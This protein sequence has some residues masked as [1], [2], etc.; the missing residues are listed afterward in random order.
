MDLFANEVR[1]TTAQAAATIPSIK[2]I[3]KK[4]RDRG[5]FLRNMSDQKTILLHLQRPFRPKNRW[6]VVP[7]SGRTIL[8][9]QRPF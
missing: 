3:T 9:S 2:Y 8:F 4:M 5:L 6:H 7:V 1:N